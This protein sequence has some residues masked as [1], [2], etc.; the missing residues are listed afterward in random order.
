MCGEKHTIVLPS[1]FPQFFNTLFASILP[2]VLAGSRRVL[3]LSALL[4]KFH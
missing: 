3:L 1:G 2:A 4:V